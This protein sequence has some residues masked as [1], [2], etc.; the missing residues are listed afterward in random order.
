[1]PTV[2]GAATLAMTVVVVHW[3][4]HWSITRSWQCCGVPFFT[5][6]YIQPPHFLFSFIDFDYMLHF[7]SYIHAWWPYFLVVGFAGYLLYSISLLL[8]IFCDNYSL[9]YS[10]I[11]AKGAG[12]LA[13]ALKHNNT[14]IEL[15]YVVLRHDLYFSSCM[16]LCTSN[17]L[18]FL[19]IF[20]FWMPD[21]WLPIHD[22]HVVT[23]FTDCFFAQLHYA[24]V[25]HYVC[26]LWGNKVGNYCGCVVVAEAL[27]HNA[28]L[29]LLKYIYIVA[30]HNIW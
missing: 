7:W 13:E 24:C 14:L 23:G 12:D 3:Q 26:S 18:Y 11:G 5:W 6:L 1:M 16:P 9:H 25:Y 27:K 10:N 2:F 8:Y 17:M 28:T 30:M 19:S 21:L 20:F 29:T 15:K 22:Y 4:R